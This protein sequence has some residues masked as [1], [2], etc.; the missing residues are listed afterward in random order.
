MKN[1]ELCSLQEQGTE[2]EE[3][4]ADSLASRVSLALGDM[5]YRLGQ[6]RMRQDIFTVF[7]VGPDIS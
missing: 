1:C 7:E 4:E 6:A 3:Q 2:T 5:V